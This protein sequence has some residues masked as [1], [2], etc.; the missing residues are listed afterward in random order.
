MDAFA[1]ALEFDCSSSLLS[2]SRSTRSVISPRSAV[3]PSYDHHLFPRP[4]D[5]DSN[6]HDIVSSF[7]HE[8]LLLFQ[9]ARSKA[10]CSWN[11]SPAFSNGSHFQASGGH[12]PLEHTCLSR[13]RI[14][15][16]AI[17]SSYSDFLGVRD[18]SLDSDLAVLLELKERF[19]HGTLVP[20]AASPEF[21]THNEIL[22]RLASH[23]DPPDVSEAMDD[24]FSNSEPGAQ[25]QLQL[26]LIVD[27][28]TRTPKTTSNRTVAG[29][30]PSGDEGMSV[31]ELSFDA[32]FLHAGGSSSKFGD[33]PTP[34]T[35]LAPSQTVQASYS[36]SVFVQPTME[37]NGNSGNWARRTLQERRSNNF[38]NAAKRRRGNHGEFIFDATQAV[39]LG[40]EH[41]QPPPCAIP[42]P[43]AVSLPSD[44]EGM[45]PSVLQIAPPSLY[46]AP[47]ASDPSSESTTKPLQTK[48][49]RPSRPM[50]SGS[51]RLHQ[52]VPPH[53]A[54]SITMRSKQQSREE[55]E[56]E[57]YTSAMNVA[58]RHTAARLA[59]KTAFHDVK[60]PDAVI[61]SLPVHRPKLAEIP[62][63]H[64]V[65][66]SD[67]WP[68]AFGD[69]SDPTLAPPVVHPLASRNWGNT[70]TSMIWSHSSFAPAY[71]SMAPEY[72]MGPNNQCL[73]PMHYM[74]PAM[75][76]QDGSAVQVRGVKRKLGCDA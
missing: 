7:G 6:L 29:W 69:S 8:A 20:Y 56:N 57:A 72:T 39:P 18:D 15:G 14:N 50:P 61:P 55:A 30:S 17:T 73:L 64:F 36:P 9:Y 33:N 2:V 59:Q 4:C 58:S 54:K 45:T 48:K 60:V 51:R 24:G 31:V 53:L 23:E 63:G 65:A 66:I 3:S 67:L 28:G 47:P 1:S 25:L 21:P 43:H 11:D 37:E 10:N 12:P 34:T 40:L 49:T 76:Q 62:Q 5:S 13:T 68:A 74:Q 19:R 16:Q 32:H 26:Q 44:A 70:P 22:P 35:G 75:D 42:P 52:F 41:A 38:E 46:N 27:D 71:P